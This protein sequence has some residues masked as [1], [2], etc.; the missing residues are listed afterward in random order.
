MICENPTTVHGLLILTLLLFNSSLHGQTD[1]ALGQVRPPAGDTAA[2]RLHAELFDEP[3]W[4]FI[5]ILNANQ[6]KITN[7]LCYRK[8]E[9]VTHSPKG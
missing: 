4:Y 1:L 7:Q 2:G 9:I 8:W 6:R 3:G 5:T